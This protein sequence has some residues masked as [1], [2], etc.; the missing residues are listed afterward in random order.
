MHYNNCNMF[1]LP[2]EWHS[3]I[4]VNWLFRNTLREV[5][6]QNWL[7]FGQS[8]TWV[9]PQWMRLCLQGFTVIQRSLWVEFITKAY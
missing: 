9:F 1:T 5:K 8:T 3:S 7:W 6:C 2:R 4:T